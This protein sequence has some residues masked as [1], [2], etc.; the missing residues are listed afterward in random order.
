MT[1]TKVK[2]FVKS[3]F[4]LSRIFPLVYMQVFCLMCSVVHVWPFYTAAYVVC[5]LFVLSV[6]FLVQKQIN[7]IQRNIESTAR[8]QD[9]LRGQQ[10]SLSKN[11]QDMVSNDI[12]S[13]YRLKNK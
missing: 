5:L 1:P 10:L 3:L 13:L 9:Q 8:H 11:L 6:P 2:T 12:S 4:N 7:S